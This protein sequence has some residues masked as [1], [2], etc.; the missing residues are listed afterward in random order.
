V[1]EIL[2]GVMELTR[3][4][5]RTMLDERCR[6]ELRISVD[7]FLARYDAGEYD[8]EGDAGHLIMLI[9]FVRGTAFPEQ[10]P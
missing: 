8:I 3:E 10:Q 9:P 6:A 5:G 2:P 1:K 4:E 7:E